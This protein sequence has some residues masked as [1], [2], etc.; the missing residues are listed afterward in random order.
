M[1]S[2]SVFFDNPPILNG[3]EAEQL[4]QLQAYLGAMSAKL[5]EALMSITIEQMT[6]EAQAVITSGAD[7]QI[8]KSYTALKSMIVKSAE[9][10]R[11]EMDEI[12]TRLESHYTALSDQFGTYEQNLQST[13]TATA[14]GILQSYNFEERVSGLEDGAEGTDSFIRNLNQYIFSG[15][16]DEVNGKYGIAIGEGVT[17]YDAQGNPYLNNSQKKATFTMDR[18]SFWQGTTE[19]AYF[20]NGRF[21]IGHGEVTDTMRMGN[22]TWQVFRTDGSLGLMANYSGS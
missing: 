15:L 22:F 2:N 18:L 8:Q 19:M 7:T 10:V 14:N 1:A 5:N 3:K 20:S 6:P 21:Y 4:Q 13:I 11:H 12:S 9:I 17:A 16:V